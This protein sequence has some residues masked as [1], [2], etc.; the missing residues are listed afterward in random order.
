[1][2]TRKATLTL[3]ELIKT[4]GYVFKE[5]Y[6]PRVPAE[7]TVLTYIVVIGD[8]S[9]LKLKASNETGSEVSKLPK[10]GFKQSQ[11]VFYMEKR[12]PKQILFGSPVAR[13]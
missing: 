10:R 4:M 9:K 8:N 7:L 12:G 5:T 2:L 3:E 6:S 11:Q 13:V 1:M